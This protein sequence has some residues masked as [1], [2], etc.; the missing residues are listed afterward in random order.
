MK[1]PFGEEILPV[2]SP[3]GR[4]V[5]ANDTGSR[6]VIWDLETGKRLPNCVDLTSKSMPDTKGHIIDS[7]AADGETFLFMHDEGTLQR[8]S[9]REPKPRVIGA[10]P[11]RLELWDSS[12]AWLSADGNV[13][14]CISQKQIS[15]N[16][17]INNLHPMAR[18]IAVRVFGQRRHWQ[19][20]SL[21]NENIY[22]TNI[23]E[24]NLGLEWVGSLKFSPS[25]LLL[26]VEHGSQGILLYDLPQQP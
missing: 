18:N 8:C 2:I 24:Y 11:F 3:D 7:W 22:R 13:V 10:R 23:R 16:M 25:G 20:F 6:I 14:A 1:L 9:I 4:H 15:R 26:A 5:V 17:W 19:T 21:K 12:A